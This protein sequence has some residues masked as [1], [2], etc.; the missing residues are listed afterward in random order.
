MFSSSSCNDR[1][2]TKLE[3]AFLNCLAGIEDEI[4]QLSAVELATAFN[5]LSLSSCAA[6]ALEEQAWLFKQ[7]SPQKK[8]GDFLELAL[9]RE[10]APIRFITTDF[11]LF[12]SKALKALEKNS[13]RAKLCIVAILRKR[14]RKFRTDFLRAAVEKMAESIRFQAKFANSFLTNQFYRTFD[15]I[16]EVFELDYSK[17][18]GMKPNDS[19]ERLYIG[20]GIGVQTSYVSIISALDELN[21]AQGS[22]FIDLGSGYGRLG[23]VIGI[24]RP[25]MRF[26]GYEYV[27]HRTAAA[28]ASAEFAGVSEKISFHEQD[29]AKTDFQIPSADFYYLFDPFT[30]ETY[31][32][33]FGQLIK[34]AKQKRITVATKGRACGW[35]RDAIAHEQNWQQPDIVDE[36][37]LGLFHSVG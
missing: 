30:K 2:V 19:A 33:V 23:L 13:I 22:S 18:V 25:D 9:N 32:H 14:D 28:I 4:V 8:F 31:E 37:T 7:A 36:G 15:M 24:L 11:N 5:L 17:E 34:I 1:G 16:D 29:L 10:L 12:D 35:F 27:G 21:P 6:A 3:D 20:A 26:Y